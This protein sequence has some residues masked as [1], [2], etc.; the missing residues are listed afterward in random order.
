MT[1]S[2]KH[3]LRFGAAASAAAFALAAGTP[4]FAHEDPEHEEDHEDLHVHFNLIDT[5]EAVDALEYGGQEAYAVIDGAAT[6]AGDAIEITVDFTAT[7]GVIEVLPLDEERCE[8]SDD[9]LR[10]TDDGASDSYGLLSLQLALGENG[11]PGD[12]AEYTVTGTANDGERSDTWDGRI[13]VSEAYADWDGPGS[14][15]HEAE[16]DLERFEFLGFTLDGAVAGATLNA[17]PQISVTQENR[18]QDHAGTLITF[19]NASN[20]DSETPE[21][22]GTAAAVADYANCYSDDDGVNCVVPTVL[23]AGKTYT[24]SPETPVAYEI[25]KDA[26]NYRGAYQA[27]DINTAAL[28]EMFEG[29][30]VPSGT[31]SLELVVVEE[32]EIG[33][34]EDFAGE[35]GFVFFSP[36]A[37]AADDKTPVTGDRT[38]M[39]LGAA[40]VAAAV[41]A[42]AFVLLRRRKA[43]QAE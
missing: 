26:V 10:C 32:A 40:A 31:S 15:G 42:G 6:S 13:A 23:E 11:K 8:F 29:G 21:A 4:A 2:K 12:I 14:D 3:T 38:M 37:G 20:L 28:A 1:P 19:T 34:D 36:K 39:V 33:A 30:V 41:G 9:V 7:P 24:V 5:N 27:F 25:A 16:F 22:D 17:A 43:A 35:T 18:I